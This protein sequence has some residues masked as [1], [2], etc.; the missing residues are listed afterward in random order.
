MMP[1]GARKAQENLKPSPRE[2]FS[3]DQSALFLE[4]I[5]KGSKDLGQVR[6]IPPETLLVDGQNRPMQLLQVRMV[7]QPNHGPGDRASCYSRIRGPSQ[8][9]IGRVLQ[10]EEMDIAG[11]ITGEQGETI[12]CYCATL[13]RFVGDEKGDGFACLEVPNTQCA[14]LTRRDG[15]PP[16][17]GYSTC[18][19]G[20]LV[21]CVICSTMRGHMQGDRENSKRLACLQVPHTQRTV[22]RS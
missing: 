16:I 9:S 3:L 1:S 10:P 15:S 19:D 17:T 22:T 21:A 5:S 6:M 18:H 20:K 2:L 13:K 12:W 8:V 7:I 11:F 4:N 14:I